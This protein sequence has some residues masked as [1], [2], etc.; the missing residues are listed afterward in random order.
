MEEDRVAAAAKNS[1]VEFAFRSR[2]AAASKPSTEAAPY[3]PTWTP[4]PATKM[5]QQSEIVIASALPAWRA[6]AELESGLFS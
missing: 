3:C 2:R 6:F 4:R 1:A 5:I